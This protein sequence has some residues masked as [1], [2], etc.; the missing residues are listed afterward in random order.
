MFVSYSYRDANWR[1]KFSVMLAPLTSALELWSDR[2]ELVG[3]KWREQLDAA[4]ARSDAALLLISP[5]FLASDFIMEHELPALIQ[6][7][8]P[9]VC[10]PVRPSLAS[11]VK[12]L[13]EVEWAHDPAR[14]L[15]LERNR[16]S[17]VVR[18]CRKLLEL[19]PAAGTQVW[20]KAA[21]LPAVKKLGELFNVPP[22]PTGFVARE[23]FAALR[24]ALLSGDKG[25]VGVAGQG[26]GFQ[27]TGGI[28]KTVLA[29]AIARDAEVRQ[30]FPDGVFWITVGADAD[31]TALQMNLL[32]QL[33]I[34]YPELRSSFEGISLLRQALADRRCLVVIDDVWSVAIAT[35]FRVTGPMGR[36]L[37]TTRDPGVL[38]GVGAEIERIDVLPVA[39]AKDL[40]RSLTHVR[41]LPPEADRILDATGR[42][43]L[44]LALVGAS[45]G[46]GEST[47][48]QVIQ[49]LDLERNTFLDHPYADTFK[50]MQVAVER[51]AQSDRDVYQSL[52]VYPGDTMVPIHAVQRLW[53]HLYDST[54]DETRERLRLLAARRLLS[55]DDEAISFHDLQRAFIRI[56]VDDLSL[57]HAG[58][59]AA[60]RA[61][62]PS[63]SGSW[64]Q[65]PPEEPYI[66][67]HLVYHLRGAGD[68]HSVTTLVCDLAYLA[69]RCFHA[70]SEAAA[71]DLRQ[72]AE[73][74]PDNFSIDWLLRLFT[75]WGHLFAEQSTISDLGAT[76]IRF[77]RDDAPR[78]V[79]TRALDR[80]LKRSYLAP[81]RGPLHATSIF[82]C[83]SSSDKAKVRELYRRLREDGFAP[84]LDEED[85]LPGQKWEQEIPLAIRDAD[86]VAVCLSRS[87][88]T[89]AGYVQREIKFALNAADEQPE[90]TIFLIP[91]RF[92]KC[93]VPYRLSEF[94][95]VDLFVDRGYARLLRALSAVSA[96][97]S[98]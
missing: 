22:L 82:L 58:L 41:E 49:E 16:D 67:E 93:E 52:S 6:H 84:W 59:L 19:L 92:E 51:L 60:Y 2:Q 18:T 15:A 32:A 97:R 3:D 89:K 88:T 95:W 5:D 45:I 40:L 37:Y 23:D 70:G 96:A 38:E 10:V 43:A 55:F 1:D 53:S 12:M 26:L 25:A 8:V 83:H 46:K 54:P 94:Q 42:S 73:L 48:D 4:I 64:A 24:E 33:G 77:T 9:L 87:S 98:V 74:F 47:W 80:M 34:E 79:D 30:R 39:A 17:A 44:A 75:Q 20:D 63:P 66:W 71:L 7:G 62:L 78:G 76:I 65:L 69:R 35:A 27:G 56:Q 68:N 81:R 91:V 50:A 11:T 36:V 28:G 72:A 85:L 86:A 90:G 14:P 61:L 21:P 13:E 31:L 57:Q 29:S